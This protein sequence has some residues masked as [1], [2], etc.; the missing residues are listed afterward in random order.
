[1]DVGTQREHA[2]TDVGS[3]A[4]QEQLPRSGSFAYMAALLHLAHTAFAHPCAADV[5]TQRE[6]ERKRAARRY[7]VYLVG[8]VST[9]QYRAAVGWAKLSL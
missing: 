9:R 3:R 4:M 5:G 1:M 8:R 2:Y 7:Q 6:V